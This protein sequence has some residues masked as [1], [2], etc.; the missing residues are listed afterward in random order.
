MVRSS[1]LTMPDVTV[2]DNPSGAPSTTVA[3]PTFTVDD[4]PIAMTGKWCVS[5]TLRTARSVS[6]PGR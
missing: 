4:E 1:A 3:S 2:P 6:G 5:A